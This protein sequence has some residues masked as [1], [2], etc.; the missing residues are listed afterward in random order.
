[1]AKFQNLSLKNK[2]YFEIVK[3]RLAQAYQKNNK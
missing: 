3:L 2:Y 1:M